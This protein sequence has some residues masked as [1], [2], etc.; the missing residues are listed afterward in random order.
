MPSSA[1]AH[2]PHVKNWLRTKHAVPL[3]NAIQVC[4]Q[5]GSEVLLVG[6]VRCVFTSKSRTRTCH[7]LGALP[8]DPSCSGG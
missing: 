3:S 5:D 8:Q 6:G 4:F 2:L 1:V 7:S